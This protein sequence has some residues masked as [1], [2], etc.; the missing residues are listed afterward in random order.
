MYGSVKFSGLRHVGED[1]WAEVM[2]E[3]HLL[4]TG[5]AHS[6]LIGCIDLRKKTV[7]LPGKE[8]K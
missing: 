4:S 5:K 3:A 6:L 8:Y 1:E 2:F 7:K